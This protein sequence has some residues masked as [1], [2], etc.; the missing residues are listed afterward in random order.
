MSLPRKSW[1]FANH[2]QDEKRPRSV[3]CS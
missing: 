3:W 1:S 2:R